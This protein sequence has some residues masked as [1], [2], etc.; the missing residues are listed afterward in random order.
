M[1][2]HAPIGDVCVC[3]YSA[4]RLV[5]FLAQC[6]LNLCMDTTPIH[7]ST[8]SHMHFCCHF[9]GL[10]TG[11]SKRMW[12]HTGLTKD[13]SLLHGM[14]NHECRIILSLLSA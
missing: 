6:F 14:E 12:G 9:V 5:Y 11:D 8:F 3:V 7:T 4:T 13:D 1:Y 2:L 10:A